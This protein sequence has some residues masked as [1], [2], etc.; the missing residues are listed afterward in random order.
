MVGECEGGNGVKKLRGAAATRI[1][2][3]ERTF[4]L[5]LIRPSWAAYMQSVRERE[6]GRF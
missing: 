4:M 5:T 3:L 2:L 6:G 1:F